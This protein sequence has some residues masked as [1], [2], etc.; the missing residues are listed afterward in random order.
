MKIA[1][2]SSKRY[3]RE[4]LANNPQVTENDPKIEFEFIALRLDSTTAYL[5]AGSDA[6]CAFV[7]DSINDETCSQLARLGTRCILLRCAGFNQVDLPAATKNGITVLRVPAYSPYAVA[8]FAVALLLTVGRKTHKAY[9]RTRESNFSLFGLMGFDVH[10]K[11]IGVCG[12]G[13]IGRLFAKIML[14]FGTKV[15][16]YD[17][18]PSAEAREMG[19]EYV[20][21]DELYAQA[22]IISLHCP[23][24]PTTRHMIGEDAVSKMKKGAILINTSRG[25]LVNMDA[26]IKGL[27]EKT[28]GACAMDVVEG[29]AALFFDD[30]SGE[31]LEDEK[32]IMLMSFPNVLITPHIAFCTDTALA[33]IWGTTVQNMIEFTFKGKDD[34]SKLTNEV[35]ID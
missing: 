15:I 13:K 20:A 4:F 30:H 31:I 25:E 24:L 19:V 16:A 2:F 22:D 11:T 29:E 21:L 14:S 6:V 32:I 8:E 9:N 7:N 12:T 18:Y 35:L 28:I 5:A 10:G 23:L 17:V 26:L 33:N 27:K 3:E 1:V 34:S